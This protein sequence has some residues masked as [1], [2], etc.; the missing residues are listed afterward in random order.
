M[1]P[2][3]R[4]RWFLWG[5]AGVVGAGIGIWMLERTGSSPPEVRTETADI[6]PLPEKSS[7]AVSPPV[8]TAE[9][10][11]PQKPAAAPSMQQRVLAL[12]DKVNAA[13]EELEGLSAPE[14]LERLQDAFKRDDDILLN[15][16]KE[17]LITLG[18]QGDEAV[19]QAL[20]SAIRSS[21]PPLQAYLIG[22]LGEIGNEKALAGLLDILN[23]PIAQTGDSRIA[24]L[25]AIAHIG[26]SPPENASLETLSGLLEKNFD[27]A[28]TDPLRR[29]AL[30]SGL[31]SVGAASGIEKILRESERLEQS[32][33]M[34]PELEDSIF[35]SLR[36]LRNPD[37]L[38]TLEARLRQDPAMRLKTTRATGEALASMGEPRAT[39]TLL[40]WAAEVSS[41]EQMQQALDWLS[42]VRDEQ[43]LQILQHAD[44]NHRFRDP[45]MR[46]EINRLANEIDRANTP[47][48]DVDD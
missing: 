20:Q 28:E 17:R 16:A 4:N 13:K 29:N 1:T 7:P 23:S 8:S 33:Q 46:E 36:E 3:Q 41:P 42:Q 6:S 39:E 14:M 11:P 44:E 25:D 22:A 30:L 21:S 35:S 9:I 34:T 10:N 48:L 5:A 18:R 32:K 43:S 45:K 40:K 19:Q 26:Q 24:A 31:S 15:I 2:K 12:N 47:D 27:L 38:P 37:A